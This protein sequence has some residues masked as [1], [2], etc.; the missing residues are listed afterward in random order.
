[1]ATS[2][3][4]GLEGEDE[5]DEEEVEARVRGLRVSADAWANDI[6]LVAVLR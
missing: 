4:G 3:G 5:S 6:S 1:M 2:G